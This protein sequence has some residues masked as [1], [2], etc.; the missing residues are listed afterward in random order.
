MSAESKIYIRI[1][2][3]LIHGQVI[4]GWVKKLGIK[5]L[6]VINDRINSDD[7]QK[8]LISMSVPEDTELHILPLNGA[9]KLS[10]DN[11][12][13]GEKMLIVL[14]S[15]VDCYEVINDLPAKNI[16]IG[17]LH[18]KEKRE[19][20]FP[21]FAID[22]NDKELLL[23]LLKQGVKIVFQS[24]PDYKAVNISDILKND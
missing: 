9:C 12:S 1:D 17:G 11:I 20:I 22:L 4:V 21:N 2:D 15:I 18:Y 23:K 8:K 6:V 14:E 10:I 3:R 24:L 13:T 16:I 7:L 19:K 5:K